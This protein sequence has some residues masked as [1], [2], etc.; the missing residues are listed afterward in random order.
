MAHPLEKRISDRMAELRQLEAEAEAIRL[1]KTHLEAEIA[2]YKDALQFFLPKPER[3]RRATI[4]SDRRSGVSDT[5]KK[6]IAQI[7]GSGSRGFSTDDVMAHSDLMGLDMKRATVRA[8]CAN[9]VKAGYLERVS[10]GHFAVTA[11]GRNAFGIDAVEKETAGGSL[12]TPT[13]AAS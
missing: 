11:F 1:R 4:P 5:W 2:A 9:F 7:S 12:G 13:P 3:Q 6:T 10:E 8:Q